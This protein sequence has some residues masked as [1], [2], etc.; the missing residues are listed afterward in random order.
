MKT[1]EH[2]LHKK[3]EFNELVDKE[4]NC[5]T[6]IHLNVCRFDMSKFC[7]NHTF[8]CSAKDMTACRTCIH[9]FTRYDDKQPIFCFKC[10]FYEEKVK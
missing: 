3:C 7:V 9:K 5:S 8:S 1:I 4:T 10:K 6:C 2:W